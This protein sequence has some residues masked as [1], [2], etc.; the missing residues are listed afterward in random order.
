M[1][2]GYLFDER[3]AP[4]TSEFGFVEC[5]AG[6]VAARYQEWEESV[7]RQRGVKVTSRPIAGTL[8]QMLLQL[9]PLTSVEP[10]RFEF[11]TSHSPWVAYFDNGWQGSDLAGLKFIAKELG[12]RA[13]RVAA[14][15]DS[16]GT[17]ADRYATEGRFGAFIFALYGPHP[18]SVCVV[19]DGGK[20]VFEAYGEPLPFE[21]I[22][23]YS[24]KRIRDRFDLAMLT[25]Y[26]GALGIRAFD[27]DF[28]GDSGVLLE[29]V[30]PMAPNVTEYSIAEARDWKRGG[31]VS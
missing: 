14:V 3:L 4:V 8:E 31:T 17:R 25:A 26:L 7:L 13:L 24:R 30:G 1:N 28:Y 21:D 27:P 6:R 10:R 2:S 22:Q 20:W 15:P 19:N 18:R 5:D 23:A 16:L 12:C 29:R 11:V 9:Q